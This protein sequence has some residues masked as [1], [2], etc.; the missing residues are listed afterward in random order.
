M[1]TRKIRGGAETGSEEL[2]NNPSAYKYKDPSAAASDLLMYVLPELMNRFPN[3]PGQMFE[4]KEVMQNGESVNQYWERYTGSMKYH[5]Q[6]FLFGV[7]DEEKLRELIRNIDNI[8]YET[9]TLKKITIDSEQEKL[10]PVFF[11]VDKVFGII[12]GILSDQLTQL[13]PRGG[14]RKKRSVRRVTNR[15]KRRNH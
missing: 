2:N 6:F 13:S 7:R 10:N 8:I 1:S 9:R 11:A 15:R 12:K 4:T 14:S 3:D 5:G